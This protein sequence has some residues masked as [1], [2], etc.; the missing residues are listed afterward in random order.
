MLSSLIPQSY[1]IRSRLKS[2][3]ESFEWPQD[4]PPK[5]HH[6]TPIARGMPEHTYRRDQESHHVENKGGERKKR[7][8][9]VVPDVDG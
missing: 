7:T 2:S 6:H 5:K 9:T 8:L 1:L 4:S 3:L